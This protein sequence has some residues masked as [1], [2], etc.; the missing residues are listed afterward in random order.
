MGL[1]TDLSASLDT[2][3][4]AGTLSADLSGPSSTLSALELPVDAEGLSQVTSGTADIDT[5]G[6]S[7][8]VSVLRDAVVAPDF[9]YWLRPDKVIEDKT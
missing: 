1:T 7:N 4:L 2:G 5:S 8:S 3:S 6:V 9:A